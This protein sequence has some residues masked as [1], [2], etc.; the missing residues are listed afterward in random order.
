VQLA[1]HVSFAA[2]ASRRLVISCRA[3]PAVAAVFDLAIFALAAVAGEFAYRHGAFGEPSTLSGLGGGLLTGALYVSLAQLAG[4]YRL[5]A[6]LAPGAS[7]ARL[8][9]TVAVAQLAAICVLFL[10]KSGADHSRGATIA[11]AALALAL[12]PIGRLG[13]AR[14]SRYAI[15]H[16]AL[17]GCRVVT[18]GD[19]FELER[20]D[21][22]EFPQFGMEEVAR[23]RLSGAAA[24]G[25]GLIER[26]R[27]RVAQ[28]VAQAREA[29]ATEFALV[30]PW[31][32]DAALSELCALLSVSPLPVRLYPD[33]KIRRAMRRGR[34]SGLAGR[35]SV[36]LQ[37]APLSPLERAAKRALDIALAAAALV[38]LAP[39]L[40]ALAA[41][42][43]LDSPGPAIFRQRRC[44]FDNRQFVMFKFRTMR[45]LED[46][47]PLVQATRDDRRV[48]RVGR[49]LRRAS[50]DELPQIVN[51][52]RGEMSLVGPRPHAIAH[53]DE[54][55]ARIANYA[56]RHH[57]KPGLTGAAQVAGL[58]GATPHL[59]QMERRVERDLWYIDNWS[60]TLDL[61]IMAATCGALLR[62]DAY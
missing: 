18:L 61:K 7:L 47:G 43:K 57:V 32:A 50:L 33:E 22:A 6:L 19:P 25:G 59:S 31:G 37:R 58:R 26:D 51:V 2:P 30:M 21:D 38:V 1:S 40:L 52:L 13:L 8:V 54:F 45:V 62:L 11:A 17:Q 27:A 14:L 12:I 49:A 10:L 48:T 39:A 42:V 4:L 23:L 24:L 9:M 3:L 15:R 60:M 5:P 35:L 53:D 29:R 56:L 44:G 36:T 41:L 20:L 28:A 34:E 16:G 55:K 46:E